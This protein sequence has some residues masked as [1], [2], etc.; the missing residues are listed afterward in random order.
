MRGYW[1]SIKRRQR[2]NLP[3]R[4]VLHLTPHAAPI[5]G[6]LTILVV[7]ERFDD[8]GDVQ[9]RFGPVA[10]PGR[11]H[12]RGAITCVAPPAIS[13]CFHNAPTGSN[14]RAGDFGRVSPNY[15]THLQRVHGTTIHKVGTPTDGIDTCPFSNVLTSTA[16]LVE[17]SFNG[18][19]FTRGS[20]AL[21]TWY[22]RSGVLLTSMFPTSGAAVSC[23]VL[24]ARASHSIVQYSI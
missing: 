14:Y 19:D 12:H 5:D 10:V 24:S 4:R 11:F 3:P 6:N 15:P 1:A 8:F 23:R 16:H 7:G 2:P 13:L 9:C 18:V 17:V 22:N 20:Q 21:F